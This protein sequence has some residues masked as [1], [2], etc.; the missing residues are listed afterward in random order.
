MYVLNTE[1]N[2][3]TLLSDLFWDFNLLLLHEVFRK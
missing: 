2:G 3:K 1:F